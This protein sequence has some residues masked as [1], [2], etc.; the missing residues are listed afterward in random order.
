MKRYSE[1]R[2]AAVMTCLPLVQTPITKYET[3]SEIFRK[4]HDL[5]NKTNM[6]YAHIALDEGAAIKAHRVIWNY[7]EKWYY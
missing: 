4:S 5:A 6:K 7:Q 3:L 2:P 1:Q